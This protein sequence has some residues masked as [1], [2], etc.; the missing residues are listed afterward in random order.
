M[1]EP[2]LHEPFV[3]SPTENNDVDEV[4]RQFRGRTESSWK[5]QRMHVK[6]SEVDKNP[7][8]V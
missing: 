3:E 5:D 6:V 8:P 7:V 4:D 2:R 1:E